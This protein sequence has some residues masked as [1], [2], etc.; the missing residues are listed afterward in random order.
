MTQRITIKPGDSL[1]SLAFDYLGDETQWRQLGQQLNLSV[2]DPLITGRSLDIPTKKELL[3]F[4]KNVLQT[5]IK[6]RYP[7]LDLS[8]LK[9]IPGIEEI[10]LI[11]W[12]L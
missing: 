7:G 6:K 5:E 12:I 11:D 9:G 1:V 8:G 10:N 3:D 4:G 2:F